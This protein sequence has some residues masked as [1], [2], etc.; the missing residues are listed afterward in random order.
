MS[1]LIQ[2]LM[3]KDG[4]PMIG[5]V[6][7]IREL[8]SG[9]MGVVYGGWHTVLDI[10]VAV[11]LLKAT[12]GNKAA[13]SRFLQ[14]ARICAAID[15]PGLVRVFDF[16]QIDVGAYLIMEYV[17]G[18]NLEEVV[19]SI[20]PMSESE[21][22]SLLRDMAVTLIALH[23]IDVVHRD[24]KPSNL[25]LRAEDGR[26]KLTD[27]GI[28]KVN[29][30]DAAPQST[31]VAGTPSFMS[32][33]QF[34]D[35]ASVGSASDFFSL[36]ATAF[37]LLTGRRPYD[38]ETLV[39][40]MKKICEQP[41]PIAELQQSSISESTIKLL[42]DLTEKSISKR[43]S[44]SR[45]LLTRL[46]PTSIPFRTTTL[47]GARPRKKLQRDDVASFRTDDQS[48]SP[49]NRTTH[50]QSNEHGQTTISSATSRSLLICKCLQND[51]IGPIK[52]NDPLPNKLHIGRQES[53]R[54]VGE[55][56]ATGPL[57][58][59]LSAC[60]ATEQMR[61][62][63]IRDWHDPDDPKQQ[64]ELEFFGPHC[65]VG[66]HGAQFVDAVEAFSRDRGRSAVVDATGINDFEDTPFEATL[67]ALV[68]DADRA[69]MPVGV[70]GVWTN[71]KVHYLLYDLKTRAGFQN[72]ATCSK[73]V[74][75]PNMQEHENAL[76]QLQTVL[77]VKVFDEVEDFLKF[78][79][80]GPATN[81]ESNSSDASFADGIDLAA[82]L[83]GETISL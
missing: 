50:S 4:T 54:I 43:I 28:A 74:A 16:D 10:P 58:T 6:R 31:G 83:V 77:G 62:V 5:K 22:L 33:E 76:R 52:E 1:N 15:D 8:G 64:P 71:V 40:T 66:T 18:R 20:G 70:I 27:L 69:T 11:K 51:F 67:D 75:A 80:A 60:A 38:S 34:L 17:A 26:T 73:L 72:L 14:E 19:N 25:M 57:V 2:R 42:M 68:E 35:P 49:L 3:T 41:L 44:T 79:N 30:A 24:I 61:I 23:K 12:A 48:S 9:G 59:A 53:L 21:V 29:S 63:H 56:P 36:G 82:T 32:P 46:P 45:Q 13:N 37:F 55:D 39:G 81:I 65:I 7:L 47:N 78:L